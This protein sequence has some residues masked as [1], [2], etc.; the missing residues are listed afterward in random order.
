MFT[1]DVA[2]IF[3]FFCAEK[4][5][6]FSPIDPPALAKSFMT[7]LKLSRTSLKV[8]SKISRRGRPNIVSVDVV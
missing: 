1:T 3:D 2:E 4:T 8:D 5:H 7:T 6:F